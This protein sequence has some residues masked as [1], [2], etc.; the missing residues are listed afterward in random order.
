MLGLGA[1]A[2]GDETLGFWGA[3]GG[4]RKGRGLPLSILPW[5]CSQPPRPVPAALP[6]RGQPPSPP[7]HWD[8][9]FPGC[10]RDERGLRRGRGW[11]PEIC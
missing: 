5:G 9:L 10:C 1:I 4:A 6:A 2:R 3:G 11:G 8:P 7:L